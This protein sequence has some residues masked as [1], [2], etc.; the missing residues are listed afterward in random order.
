MTPGLGHCWHDENRPRTFDDYCC[1][2]GQIRYT[3]YASPGQIPFDSP[4]GS[5]HPSSRFVDTGKDTE[6]CPVRVK[7]WKE[8][9]SS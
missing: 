2:C 6:P 8:H 3:A 4:H 5:Y 9:Q 1:W 7:L